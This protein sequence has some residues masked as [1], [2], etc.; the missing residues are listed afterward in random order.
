MELEATFSLPDM[1]K[2]IYVD[3]QGTGEAAFYRAEARAEGHEPN[4]PEAS[5]IVAVYTL[6]G[7]VEVSKTVSV[8]PVKE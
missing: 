3:R 8:T 7:F 2:T 1:P 4:D 6:T 5:N